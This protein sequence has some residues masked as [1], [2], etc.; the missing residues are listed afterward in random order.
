MK[1]P[2]PTYDPDLVAAIEEHLDQDAQTEIMYTEPMGGA[3]F[4]LTRSR[5]RGANTGRLH[6]RPIFQI[7]GDQAGNGRNLGRTPAPCAACYDFSR[8]WNCPDHAE[9]P[10]NPEKYDW[11]TPHLPDES[12]CRCSAC[13]WSAVQVYSSPE[14]GAPAWFFFINGTMTRLE[15][16]GER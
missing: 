3:G 2:Q 6:T 4:E 14:P 15:I 1:I 7:I 11:D 13:L 10:W 8:T 12:S 9:V 16:N 5:A